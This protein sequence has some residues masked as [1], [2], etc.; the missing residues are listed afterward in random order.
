MIVF[1]SDWNPQVD[2]QAIDRAHRIGQT[3][4]VRVFRL[5][6]ENTVDEKIVE[7]AERKMRL[8]RL[9][10]QQ[11]RIVDNKTLSAEERMAIISHGANYVLSSTE[12]DLID[13]DI[14]KILARSEIRTAELKSQY[15]KLGE[16]ALQNFKIEAPPTSLNTFEGVD[17]RK[18][19]NKEHSLILDR[20]MR[21]R[22]PVQYTTSPTKFEKWCALLEKNFR[23]YPEPGRL[24]YLLDVSESDTGP[25]NA[26]EKREMSELQSKGFHL[27]TE[28]Q[29]K[30]YIE[31][32][33][34][35]GRDD[36]T[37]V[38]RNV[39]GRKTSEV[40][41]YDAAF[42]ER[43]PKV[44]Q[45]FAVIKQRIERHDGYRRERLLWELANVN[46]ANHMQNGLTTTAP[47]APTAPTLKEENP[48]TSGSS[49]HCS[50]VSV[51]TSSSS[52][53][54]T[55]AGR[56]ELLLPAV[57]MQMDS[58]RKS[59]VGF[60]QPKPKPDWLTSF[61]STAASASVQ[62]K[63][64][65]LTFRSHFP[66]VGAKPEWLAPIPPTASTA[67]GQLKSIFSTGLAANSIE[68][69]T[70]AS[71]AKRIRTESNFKEPI[72][73]NGSLFYQ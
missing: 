67:Q 13:D 41:A 30:Q 34:K 27:W 57:H 4:Q 10:I 64:S 71:D 24:R 35:F 32:L 28:I 19:R 1:D 49:F 45:N 73:V 70:E 2:L 68:S 66:Q 5:I 25:L 9:V 48:S 16:G 39:K 6:T 50:G 55:F 33:C 15:D 40:I 53:N 59:D 18:L 65:G 20:S 46:G 47:T 61:P 63:P 43:G 44:V 72:M 56:G 60:S 29:F 3:K 22:K 38:S 54:K 12:S 31:A 58:N 69:S 62:S 14:D 21:R 7:V 36:I 26:E 8:D 52:D 51:D 37:N 23:L 11:G 42:W 17:F